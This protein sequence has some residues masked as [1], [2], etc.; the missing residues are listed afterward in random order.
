MRKFLYF[1]YGFTGYLAFLGVFLYMAAFVGN[2]WITNSI[3]G[4]SVGGFWGSLA[5]DLSLVALFGLQHSVM[6]RPGFKQWWTKI[7]PKPI[8]RST[9]VWFTNAAV[10]LLIWQWRPLGGMVWTVENE[11]ARAVLWTLFGAGWLGVVATTH[12]INHFE[13]FGLSQVYNYLRGR[14]LQ[15]ARFVTPGPYK[16]VRHPLYVC[17]LVAF[18]ATPTMSLAHLAFAAGMTAYIL[19]AIRF[20]ER[21]LA[22]YHGPVYIRYRNH[23]PML[24]PKFGKAVDAQ[25][26]EP[27]EAT[28]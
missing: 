27:E 15:P 12:L 24:V 28:V 18:W 6:A 25:T 14:D 7:V 20:E 17:W 5:I 26:L 1:I 19:I 21:D 11:T 4:A 2:L 3:D 10:L 22:A 9:Y 8:E 13:L 16:R 23:V